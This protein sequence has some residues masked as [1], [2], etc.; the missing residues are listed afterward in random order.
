MVSTTG[1]GLLGIYGLYHAYEVKNID[2]WH[3]IPIA[4]IVETVG[5]D[6]SKTGFSLFITLVVTTI[7]LGFGGLLPDIDSKRSILG[8]YVPFVE[9]LVGH[10]TITHTVWVVAGL[11]AL[12]YYT[13][14]YILWMITLGY[15]L[16][17]IQDS[18]SVQGIDWFWP[19]GRGY[20]SYGGASVKRGPHLGLYRVG[21]AV[22]SAIMGVM[23]L[24]NIWAI[25]LWFGVII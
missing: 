5:F 6:F 24:L 7:A 16:H 25:Y 19:I 2:V 23:I 10:R 17:I 12:S 14:F 8:R 20:S 11:M 1:T 22:E 21:G 4:K 3:N 9:G 13:G 18:F 15:L